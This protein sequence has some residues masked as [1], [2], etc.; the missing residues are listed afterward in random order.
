MS[1]PKINEQNPQCSRSDSA[2]ENSWEQEGSWSSGKAS[3]EVIYTDWKEV[4]GV[5]QISGGKSSSGREKRQCKGPGVGTPASHTA[6]REPV[7][8]K[9]VLRGSRGK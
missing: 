4:R 5:L 9:G 1:R 8:A 3:V 7:W 6:A 2:I